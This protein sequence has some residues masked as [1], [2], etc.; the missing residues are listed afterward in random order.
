MAQCPHR[1][2][3]QAHHVRTVARHE[4]DHLA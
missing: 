4:L 3:L 1:K 2:L